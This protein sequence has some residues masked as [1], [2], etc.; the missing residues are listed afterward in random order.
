MTEAVEV[1]GIVLSSMPVGE[2]DRRLSILTKELGRISAFARG[3]RKPTS[4]LIAAT[5][6]FATGKFFIYPGR[7]AFSLNK[8]EIS[9][10]FEEIVKDVEKTAYGSYFL[11][12]ATRFSHEHFDG[13]NQL[14][15][16]YLSLKALLNEKIPMPLTRRV[17]ELKTLTYEGVI[18][19]FTE[20][21]GAAN[22]FSL[23]KSAVFALRF[24]R[25]TELK[26]LYTFTVTPEVLREIARVSEYFVSANIDRPLKSAEMIEI[27]TNT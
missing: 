9:E 8:A 4:S 26:K 17:Y 14:N 7:D 15:L 6:P 20:G 22:P 1:N 23:S 13:G 27:L 25:E 24:I 18:P 11:E 10:H 12:L 19:E 16:L 2:S 3:A 21:Q 5:R